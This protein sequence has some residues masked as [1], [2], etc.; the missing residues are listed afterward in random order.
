MQ[1]LIFSP[2]TPVVYNQD[3]VIA[4][5]QYP[6]LCVFPSP[7]VWARPVTFQPVNISKVVGHYSC[8]C[9]TLY[10]K[11]ENVIKIPNQLTLIAQKG[12]Y[13]GEPDLII[14]PLKEG[15]CFP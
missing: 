14:S 2:L 13:P 9:V 15:L 4:T 1:V 5:L 8:G 11:G 3:M 10:G 7:Q 12:D 6:C